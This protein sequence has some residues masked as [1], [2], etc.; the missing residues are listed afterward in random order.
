MNTSKMRLLGMLTFMM[1]ANV[2]AG[3]E[4]TNSFKVA[5]ASKL[6]MEVGGVKKKID[7]DTEYRYTWKRKGGE[8]TLSMDLIGLRVVVDGN[9]VSKTTMARRKIAT[10]T[11]GELKEIPFEDAPPPLKSLMQ[12]TFE[13]PICI[14]EFDDAGKET[15][16]KVVAGPGAKALVENG[17][18]ENALIFHPPFFK[19]KDKWDAPCSISMGNGGFV[20][21]PLTYEKN[22]DAVKVSGI[23]TIKNQK[24]NGPV[25]AKDVRYIIK[26]Q[27]KFDVKRMEWASGNL[28]IDVTMV[29]SAE[30]QPDINSKGVIEINFENLPKKN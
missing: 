18:I 11:N 10:V 14:L 2:I 28:T 29:L 19:D 22:G 30:N 25:V 21:G 24:L 9:E 27:Q 12:D 5:L 23:L 1:G 13:T 17:Q 26:G 8:H 6:T 20:R 16:R 4:T 7:A 15:K 3:G